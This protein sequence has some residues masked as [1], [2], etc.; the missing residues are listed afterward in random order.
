MNLIP[1]DRAD[2]VEMT[3][4]MYS[5]GIRIWSS[6]DARPSGAVPLRRDADRASS[7][8][9]ALSPDGACVVGAEC[10][11][12][13]QGHDKLVCWTPNP[14]AAHTSGQIYAPNQPCAVELVEDI[15]S[16]SAADPSSPIGSPP[17]DK[18]GKDLGGEQVTCIAFSPCGTM[19]LTACVVDNGYDTEHIIQSCAKLWTKSAASGA[20]EH[21][22][23]FATAALGQ[24][25]EGHHAVPGSEVEDQPSKINAVAFSANGARVV[26]AGDDGCAILWDVKL[27]L[28][29]GF[30]ETNETTTHLHY[31][32]PKFS[33]EGVDNNTLFNAKHRGHISRENS[34]GITK[35]VSVIM[36]ETEI[37]VAEKERAAKQTPLERAA[38]PIVVGHSWPITSVAF[39]CDSLGQLLTGGMDGRAVL[40]DVPSD[41]LI[42]EVRSCYVINPDDREQVLYSH[43]WGQREPMRDRAINDVAFLEGHRRGLGSNRHGFDTGSRWATGGVDG[44]IVVWDAAT[45]EIVA[46]LERGHGGLGAA[47]KIHAVAF[48]RDGA[49]LISGGSDGFACL[50]DLTTQIVVARLRHASCSES[51]KKSV[52]SVAIRDVDQG[53]VMMTAGVDGSV[54]VYEHPSHQEVRPIGTDLARTRAELISLS[55]D[56]RWI[57]T[58][59]NDPNPSVDIWDTH[60][61]HLRRG[62]NAGGAS[63]QAKAHHG[64]RV[65]SLKGLQHERHIKHFSFVGIDTDHSTPG[66]N[67]PWFW[68]ALAW[69]HNG[70]RILTLGGELG[71]TEAEQT[72]AIWK[73]P[74]EEMIRR[75]NHAR[76]KHRAI[77]CGAAGPGD[78]KVRNSLSKPDALL[79]DRWDYVELGLRSPGGHDNEAMTVRCACWTP[80]GE[81]V[82]TGEDAVLA[83]GDTD[84]ST[85]GWVGGRAVVWNVA[86]LEAGEVGIVCVLPHVDHANIPRGIACL[87]AAVL[88][89]GR[90]LCV[91]GGDAGSCVV[92][93]LDL[94]VALTAEEKPPVPHG[95]LYNAHRGHAEATIT[96]VRFDPLGCGQTHTIRILTAG[97]LKACMW[98]VVLILLLLLQ[99]EFASLILCSSRFSLPLSFHPPPRSVVLTSSPE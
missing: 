8:I 41:L 73:S 1:E 36:R 23:N 33:G 2:S 17:V 31:G 7:S 64:V 32:H 94:A 24:P 57:I 97:S 50:W 54:R 56:G 66:V 90:R 44:T 48:A 60:P 6:A 11:G 37:M 20:W 4:V 45:H 85:P 61:L 42:N 46:R 83:G 3:G 40:W 26:T 49:T 79:A 96:A 39:S 87:R 51:T 52:T 30:R 16:S 81:R 68:G 18:D 95:E 99:H 86:K 78:W 65:A 82:V 13:D 27:L 70:D 80:D 38:T 25:M 71:A 28:T 22:R 93:D 34:K 75:A 9:A 77:S 53:R 88:N 63:A 58:A 98:C 19:L 74:P 47:A 5:E 89:S 76:K 67:L 12:A 14:N 43:R 29:D 21:R 10:V 62:A 69:N 91:T 59:H 72:C 55:P 15:G 92:W 35:S 84:G